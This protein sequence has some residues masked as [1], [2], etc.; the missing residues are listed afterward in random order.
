MY[1]LYIER[2]VNENLFLKLKSG[3]KKIE[4]MTEA[5]LEQLQD[6]QVTYKTQ[7]SIVN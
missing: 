6:L 2:G 1:L 3:D 4:S 5:T 7:Y